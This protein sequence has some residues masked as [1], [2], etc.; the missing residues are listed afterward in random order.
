MGLSMQFSP[1]EKSSAT[2]PV[3]LMD[4][5]GRPF[6]DLLVFL[7]PS[8]LSPLKIGPH[9]FDHNVLCYSFYLLLLGIS[10][11]EPAKTFSL[12]VLLPTV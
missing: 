3:L 4:S 12:Q 10:G 1:L 5:L 9:P 8:V 6:S 7:P 11:V 2:L